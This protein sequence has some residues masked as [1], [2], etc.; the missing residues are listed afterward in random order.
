MTEPGINV[1]LET[2]RTLGKPKCVNRCPGRVHFILYGHAN[3][4]ESRV[5]KPATSGDVK[6]N[7]F[8]SRSSMF[9]AYNLDQQ[10]L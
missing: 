7:T 1:T 6:C 3:A 10:A 4:I 5:Y 2:T 8:E 9:Q